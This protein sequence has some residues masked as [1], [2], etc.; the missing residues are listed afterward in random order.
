MSKII[1]YN[2]AAL[3]GKLLEP[4]TLNGT[5]ETVLV[6]IED[7]KFLAQSQVSVY[8]EAELNSSSEIEIRYYSSP[9]KG[10]TWYQ[11]PTKDPSS[12][13]LEDTPTVLDSTSPSEGSVIRIVE[14][15]PVSAGHAFRVTAIADGDSAF[16][17]INQCLVLFRDN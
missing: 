6:E 12:G 14:D 9:D 11:I 16:A 3:G 4:V 15:I 2:P 5:T 10:L 8:L 13:V 17:G 7:D 1:S